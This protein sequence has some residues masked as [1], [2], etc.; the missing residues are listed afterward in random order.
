MSHSV[1]HS[2]ATELLNA[3]ENQLL[4]HTV[5]F[6][7]VKV[8]AMMKKLCH[9]LKECRRR[10][11]RECPVLAIVASSIIVVVFVSDWITIHMISWLK[12]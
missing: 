2:G 1:S 3:V 12:L 10:L 6:T 9:R 7:C 11:L 8:Y 5:V 4:F